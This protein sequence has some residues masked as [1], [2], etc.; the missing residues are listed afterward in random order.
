MSKVK[1]TIMILILSFS[2]IIIPGCN[3]DEE[4]QTGND[5]AEK[6]DNGKEIEEVSEEIELTRRETPQFI[7]DDEIVYSGLRTEYI[8]EED[9]QELWEIYYLD[10]QEETDEILF[11]KMWSGIL[12]LMDY[13]GEYLFVPS[14]DQELEIINEDLETVDILMADW[15]RHFPGDDYLYF[16][17]AGM[18]PGQSKLEKYNLE[19]SDFETIYDSEGYLELEMISQGQGIM[20]EEYN[21]DYHLKEIDLAEGTTE[22]I[23]SLNDAALDMDAGFVEPQEQE[24]I[25]IVQDTGA[26]SILYGYDLEGNEQESLELEG[27]EPKVMLSPQG[28]HL[29]VKTEDKGGP[30][31]EI[32]DL[33]NFDIIETLELNNASWSPDGNRLVYET[34][35][36]DVEIYELE[37]QEI[38]EVPYPTE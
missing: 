27:F 17:P 35:L 26:S 7:S 19:S 36:R 29:V 24:M 20:Y 10:L 32:I 13:S 2:L 1:S 14:G 6:D 28:N 33:E 12:P 9:E 3:N 37:S 16:K 25:F 15:A 31:A 30:T 11:E 38:Q 5:T 23:I 8:D 34:P 22:D 4:E 21:T 18:E